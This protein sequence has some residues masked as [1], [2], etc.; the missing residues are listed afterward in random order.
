MDFKLLGKRFLSVM[1][2]L[3]MAIPIVAIAPVTAVA[4][5]VFQLTVVSAEEN[6]G[7]APLAED[8]WAAFAPGRDTVTLNG[9]TARVV[10]WNDGTGVVR[11]EG[12]AYA[13][14]NPPARAMVVHV[15]GSSHG[16]NAAGA[17]VPMNLPVA[18]NY[19]LY[20]RGGHGT[21]SAVQYP[22]ATAGAL[23]NR[24]AR[25]FGPITGIANLGV[26][27][28][29][30]QANNNHL[31]ATGAATNGFT[32]SVPIT[33]S[34]QFVTI[35]F[36]TSMA[37]PAHA[38]NAGASRIANPQFGGAMNAAGTAFVNDSWTFANDVNDN[39]R[40]YLGVVTRAGAG[41]TST[42][43]G[44]HYIA[45]GAAGGFMVG[46]DVDNSG[47]TGVRENIFSLNGMRVRAEHRR[48]TSA[49]SSVMFNLDGVAGESG[50][51]RLWFTQD[52]AIFGGGA[53]TAA[54]GMATRANT[55]QNA[56]S[57]SAMGQG[58]ATIGPWSGQ[59]P[60]MQ[61][62]NFNEGDVI[63]QNTIWPVNVRAATHTILRA[64][65]GPLPSLGGGGLVNGVT[66]SATGA[67]ATGG[68]PAF[69]VNIELNGTTTASGNHR[70]TLQNIPAAVANVVGETISGDRTVDRVLYFGSGQPVNQRV[71]FT[72]TGPASAF[73]PGTA[74]DALSG[75]V[76]LHEFF[77]DVTL[78]SVATEGITASGT[79][80]LN[81][82]AGM[83]T[84]DVNFTG[85]ATRAGTYTLSLTSTNPAVQAQLDD[86][87]FV[88]RTVGGNVANSQRFVFNYSGLNVAALGLAITFDFEPLAAE[89]TYTVTPASRYNVNATST[90]RIP[91][92]SD[93]VTIMT[94]VAS[95]DG[96]SEGGLYRIAI[97]HDGAE[98]GYTTH[99]LDS[100][101]T[102]ASRR[103]I[104]QMPVSGFDPDELS[105]EIRF[106]PHVEF[107]AGPV[108][109][110]TANAIARLNYVADFAAI[111][112]TVSGD[113]QV[114]EYTVR[115]LANGIPV[116][117]TER[118]INIG[119][120]GAITRNLT[121][122]YDFAGLNLVGQNLSLE[123]NFVPAEAARGG[124]I[125]PSTANG[126]TTGGSWTI[127]AGFADGT[128][129]ITFSGTVGRSGFYR[130]TLGG[131]GFAEV[132]ETQTERFGYGVAAR[133]TMLFPITAIPGED[134]TVSITLTHL[135]DDNFFYVINHVAE[136][137]S[138]GSAFTFP[139]LDPRTP[140]V[141]NPNAPS[142][143]PEFLTAN[144]C[145]DACADDCTDP[146]SV[147]S[148]V[149]GNAYRDQVQ[150]IFN[151]RAD[152]IRIDR[153][154][155][156]VTESGEVDIS[157]QLRRGTYMGI[158]RPDPNN[159]GQFE[160]IA[161]IPLA[162][163]P[164]HREI[165]AFR[166]D[167]YVPS[168]L[169]NNE[170][171]DGEFLQNPGFPVQGTDARTGPDLEVR[172]NSDRGPLSGSIA[173]E[174]LA[175]GQR[176]PF[177]HD[178]LPRGTRGTFRIAP[179]NTVN[180]LEHNGEYTC[181][182]E[183]YHMGI[184]VTSGG[185]DVRLP[186]SEYNPGNFGSAIV[187]FRI[188]N[189][190]IPPAVSRM[191]ITPGRNGAAQ[192]I[193][194]TNAHMRVL[195]GY[196]TV[197]VD[198]V[199]VTRQVWVPLS[200]NITVSGMISLFAAQ[201]VYGEPD[202]RPAFPLPLTPNGLYNEFEIRFFRNNR[203]TSA[204]GFFRVNADRFQEATN[205]TARV[206]SV[207]IR[208]TQYDERTTAQNPLNRPN[209]VN[210]QVR[211]SGGVVTG[212]T[213]ASGRNGYNVS[214]WFV[215]ALP[216]GLSATVNQVSAG[217]SGIRI[218]I[219]GV[220]TEA[221]AGYV[222][223][224][225][226]IPPAYFADWNEPVSVENT[227]TDGVYAARI[228]IEGGVSPSVVSA[229]NVTSDYAEVVQGGTIEFA[230]QVLDQRG[231][232]MAGAAIEW[233]I[234][235]GEGPGT[236]ISATGVLTVADD[237][238]LGTITVRATSATDDTVY[239]DLMVAVVAAP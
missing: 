201:G 18:S 11:R 219:W 212:V 112:V 56:A 176:H 110:L 31:N 57:L 226:V 147:A 198:G 53:G 70:V 125:A 192:F 93:E 89:R 9:I 131:S 179:T 5:E 82:D 47:V 136:T 154:S 23:L 44:R 52:G 199:N 177:P 3:V 182:R 27:G 209:G 80:R 140:A 190:P 54:N 65:F 60:P 156:Q 200:P 165:R 58:V 133:G 43:V 205:V 104:S 17:F 123:I 152:R 118:P 155:W 124:Y 67:L 221:T 161:I 162:P 22:G 218:A 49:S 99:S 113:A 237:H 24:Q 214:D 39:I 208:G 33:V 159:R 181:V 150:F 94:Y 61:A 26:S 10:A 172:I 206:E 79:A 137:V 73:A 225:I 233:S 178:R 106:Y 45:A 36:A 170:I 213:A 96:A 196:E 71:G 122:S 184:T 151:R 51:Y 132:G 236:S 220:P 141:R 8:P 29:L 16:V 40:L 167:I 38:A 20:A 149:W 228:S 239:G 50:A 230:A 105:L 69:V 91:V 1:L 207:I 74:L 28:A 186:G 188:P 138:I 62:F 68:T 85:G 87:E 7:F 97:M 238:D 66:A 173:T 114:G 90:A 194:R 63:Y 75:M 88:I 223:L 84:A 107:S 109:G 160:L 77:P 183:L 148:I 203:V 166:R 6:I 158:R 42:A 135:P 216:A 175:P 227:E 134:V 126:V 171:Q 35:G 129:T 127:P 32:G 197:E 153:G 2:A 41:L 217:G 128:A 139:R 234:V 187:R 78:A 46:N 168:R 34:G 83:V 14:L 163:R 189:Q 164:A 4:D 222:P 193:S 92:S 145:T 174:R 59:A 231:D 95:P 64:E 119:T 55:G 211:T 13:A 185:E 25:D 111:A 101:S 229:M 108:A 204:P 195:L 12:A 157:R 98:I 191:A 232:V 21:L 115:L 116:A 210:V 76:V 86:R 103:F 146:C 19:I 202:Y 48:I 120:A 30:A 100:G 224:R 235:S 143:L 15:E 180:F 121:M 102:L 130:V 117:G 169:V 81:P 72:L 142:T 144:A 37:T 215:P